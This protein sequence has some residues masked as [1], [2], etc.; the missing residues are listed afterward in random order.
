MKQKILHT[1]I[2]DLPLFERRVAIRHDTSVSAMVRALEST[3]W[4]E[5]KL[6]NLSKTGARFQGV[7]ITVPG[8]VVVMRIHLSD[9]NKTYEYFGIVIWRS[10][11]TF[12]IQFI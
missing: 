8:A 9:M 12:G 11:G 1:K 10:K 2:G 5:A 3:T 6:I 4:A 7:L